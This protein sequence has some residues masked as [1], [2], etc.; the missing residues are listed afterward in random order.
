MADDQCALEII[1]PDF[2]K[3]IGLRADGP[4]EWPARSQR[5]NRD[6]LVSIKLKGLDDGLGRLP[7]PPVRAGEDVIEFQPQPAHPCRRLT[8][9]LPAFLGERAVSI[10]HDSALAQVSRNSVSQKIK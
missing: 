5:V 8:H 7:R 9:F 6:D 4:R 2:N 3:D 10:A 1:C